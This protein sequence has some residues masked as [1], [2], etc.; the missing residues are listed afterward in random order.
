VAGKAVGLNRGDF[1]MS[2]A[3]YGLRD[4]KKALQQFA[5]DLKKSMD[6][7]I[8]TALEPVRSR[9][10][11]SVPASAMSGW[12]SDGRGVWNGRLGWDQAQI[13][14]GIKISQGGRGR[15][16]SGVRVAWKVQSQSPAGVIFELARK[17]KSGGSFIANLNR[18]AAPSRL[19]WQAW[20]D[21]GGDERL[22]P[23]VVDAIKT[24]ED[25]LEA[26]LGAASDPPGS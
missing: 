22:T 7:E 8:R 3:I 23:K 24:A 25:A 20:D 17:S 11:G 5:P 26:R 19:I 2:V 9:A 1:G 18:H 15:R 13:R 12:R 4:T 14:K 16:G 10:Q 6:K 21:L